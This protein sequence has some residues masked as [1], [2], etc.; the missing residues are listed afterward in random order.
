MTVHYFGP[1][2]SND[3]QGRAE[4]PPALLRYRFQPQSLPPWLAAIA[5]PL[6]VSWTTEVPHPLFLVR[7]RRSGRR[8]RGTMR[9]PILPFTFHAP[10]STSPLAPRIRPGGRPTSSFA[11]LRVVTPRGS[12]E[13]PFSQSTGTALFPF[14]NP[15]PLSWEAS[16]RRG[17]ELYGR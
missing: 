11:L 12:T 1:N 7:C 10:P 8:V 13:W 2:P 6:T 15:Y 16:M 14:F 9:P 4:P 17:L 5:R 3:L